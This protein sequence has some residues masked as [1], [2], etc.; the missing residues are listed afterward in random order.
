[1]KIAV[2]GGTGTVG[3]HV[4]DTSTDRGHDT[5]VLSR[6]A[7]IDLVDGTG[8]DA[9]LDGVDAVIDVASVR[10]RS[11]KASVEFFRA[12]TT[13]LLAA[14]VRAGVRHHVTLTIVGSDRAPWGYYA[15][16]VVQEELVTHGP[17]PWTLLRAT[18]FHE[19]AAQILD[20]LTFGRIHLVPVM[21]SQ[22][23]AALEVAQRLVEHA[24]TGPAGRTREL[25][26]PDVLHMV[27]M[28]RAYT[29]AVGEKGPVLTFPLPGKLGK[30][31]R[32][33]TLTASPDADHGVQTFAQWIYEVAADG[34]DRAR[35]RHQRS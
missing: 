7:G 15:G 4:V 6:A 22:P 30:A 17:V 24:E 19:F 33:G 8:L 23:V 20:Q 27:D 25:S 26:G 9:A 5:V 35:P 13:N 31:F 14:E 1:M 11:A 28:V 29:R 21:R 34:P 12:V 18:Q 3:R 2:A 32:D 10:T 16:K